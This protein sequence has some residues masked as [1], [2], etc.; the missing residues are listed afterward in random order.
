M[1]GRG[2]R[3]VS[4]CWVV[5]RQQNGNII[6]HIIKNLQG[7]KMYLCAKCGG[8]AQSLRTKRQTN[9]QTGI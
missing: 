3:Y 8:S 5:A 4:L 9:T 6:S 7:A 1:G 2:V